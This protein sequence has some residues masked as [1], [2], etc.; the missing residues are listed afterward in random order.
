MKKIDERKIKRDRYLTKE[1]TVALMA[2][3]G[4]I[5]NSLTANATKITAGSTGGTTITNKDGVYDIETTNKKGNNA[6]NHFNQFELSPNNI[7]NMYFGTKQDNSA[8]NL[9]NFV[10]SRIEVN[11]TVNAIK[12]N[13]IGGDLYFLSS[14]GM[15]VGNTGTINTGS[16]HVITPSKTAYADA[17]QKAGAGVVAEGIVPDAKGQIKIP[18]NP[19]GT[20]VVRGQVNAVD[21]IG[22]YA[23]NIK[24]GNVKS[25]LVKDTDYTPKVNLKTGVTDFSNL[26]NIQGIDSGLKGEQLQA[27]KIGNG[28]IILMAKAEAE[29][30][31]DQAFNDMLGDIITL[32]RLDG[33]VPRNIKAS[34]EI[35]G[36]ITATGDI[37]AKAEAVNGTVSAIDEKT[38][39]VLYNSN[40]LV[41][42]TAK[43]DIKGGTLTAKNIDIDAVSTNKYIE[44]V[45][46]ATGNTTGAQGSAGILGQ[47]IK[48][49]GSIGA[50][51]GD[52]TVNIAKGSIID[53][54]ENLEINAKND[55]SLTLGSSVSARKSK[56]AKL[57]AMA[58]MEGKPGAF[59]YLPATG[60]AIGYAEG[61]ASVNVDGTLKSGG[62]M[63]IEASS[64]NEMDLNATAM[65]NKADNKLVVGLGLA[66]GNNSSSV[67]LNGATVNSSG[68]L[69][70]NSTTTNSLTSIV[71]VVAGNATPFATTVNLV[72]YD[73]SSNINIKDSS[74][75]SGENIDID[76][77]N[78]V[79]ENKIISDNTA[80]KKKTWLQ[81]FKTDKLTA[82]KNSEEA[83]KLVDNLKNLTGFGSGASPVANGE[84]G[85]QAEKKKGIGE[86]IALGAAMAF[87]GEEN[88]SSVNIQGSSINAK[89]DLNINSKTHIQDTLM[90]VAGDTVR[91][92]KTNVIIGAG[93]LYG[94]V[95]NTSSIVIDGEQVN[96]KDNKASVITTENGKI[97]IHSTT[98]MDYARVDKM[99]QELKNSIA[100]LK[101]ALN[102]LKNYSLSE[103]VKN[104]IAEL[105]NNLEGLGTE[106]NNFGSNMQGV[107]LDALFGED[108]VYQ[109][110][111]LIKQAQAV[112]DQL[113]ALSTALGENLTPDLASLM[114]S[115]T[116]SIMNATEFANVGN[117]GNFSVRATARNL[118][119][120]VGI[121]GAVSITNLQNDSK[122]VIGKGTTVNAKKD[123][124]IESTNKVDAVNVGG[125]IGQL[126]IKANGGGEKEDGVAIGGSFVMQ[127]FDSNNIIAVAEGAKLKG[128]NINITAD[129]DIFNVDAVLSAGKSAGSAIN[130]MVSYST[131]SIN[132]IVAIDDEVLLETTG[133]TTEET[134]DDNIT[135]KADSNAFVVNVAGGVAKGGNVGAGVGVA[136]NEFD[137]NNKIEIKD[138]DTNQELSNLVGHQHKNKV[139]DVIKNLSVGDL[140]FTDDKEDKQNQNPNMGVFKEDKLTI[141]KAD[142]GIKTSNFDASTLTKGE[143]NSVSVAGSVSSKSEGEEEKEGI[144][145]SLKNN[146]DS[147]VD[148]FNKKI[149]E[150]IGKFNNNGA[151][152]DLMNK[153]NSFNSSG[154]TV[155]AGGGSTESNNVV[156]NTGAAKPTINVAVA[157]SSS[158]NII[159][160]VTKT[161]VDG[162]DINLRGENSSVN[163]SAKDESFTGAWSGAAA[164]NWITK[165][166]A[167]TESGGSGNSQVSSGTSVGVHGAVGINIVDRETTAQ[168][169]NSTIKDADSIN[170][171]SVNDSVTVAAGLGLGLAKVSGAGNKNYQGGASVSLN[172]ITHNTNAFLENIDT[173]NENR[174]SNIKVNA[175]ESG[176]QVTG[177]EN[178]NAGQSSGAMGAAVTV[179]NIN[180]TINTGIKGGN[181]QD[182]ENVNVDGTLDMTQVTAAAA[183]GATSQEGSIGV[184]EGAVVYNGTNNIVNSSID[185][186]NIDASGD[187]N[188][189]AGDTKSSSDQNKYTETLKEFGIDSTGE[190]YYNGLE[191]G[192]SG[193]G[194][195]ATI[196]NNKSGS[197][198][199]TGALSVAGSN[200][201]ALGAGVVVNNVANKFTA[202]IKGTNINTISAD[203]VNVGAAAD[204]FIVG[205]AGGVGVG[206]DT[207]GGMGSVSWQELTN[208]VVSKISGVNITARE[209]NVTSKNN[210]FETNSAGQITYGGK[211]AA[212]AA[213]AYTNI[214]NL[215]SAT[216][217]NTT[218]NLKTDGDNPQE[219]NVNVVAESGVENYT[220]AAGVS[221]SA[222]NA[223]VAGS[224]AVAQGGNSTL[225]TIDKTTIKDVDNLNTI[226]T[227][228][229]KV[230]TIAGTVTGSKGAAIG[231]SG[232]YS[233]LAKNEVKAALNSVNITTG[234]NGNI[235]IGA[236]ETSKFYTIGAGVGGSGQVAVQ[237]A[238]SISQINKT[239]N[240][241]MENT[242]INSEEDLEE[243][244]TDLNIIAQSTGEVTSNASVIGGAGTAA[245]GAGTAV[246]NITQNTTATLDGGDQNL[247]NALIKAKSLANITT[248][249]IGGTGAG[250]VGITG[251]VAINQINNNTKTTVANNT[252]IANGSIG[253]IAQSDDVISN[254]AGTVAGGG[255][256]AIGAS[257]SVNQISGDTL[258]TLNNANITANGN[259][260]GIEVNSKIED[261][262][263]IDSIIDEETAQLGNNLDSKRKTEPIKGIVI[264]S[265]ATHTLKSLLANGGIAGT[266]AV[267]GTVNVNQIDGNTGANILGST[268][269]SAKNLSV[270][271]KDYTNS[272]GIV[273]TIAAGMNAGVGASSDTNIVDRDANVTIGNSHLTG[274]NLD[275]D[276]TSKQGISSFGMGFGAAV[277]GAG[278][279][280]TVTVVD[281]K[282]DTS[283]IIKDDSDITAIDGNIDINADHYGTI[284]TGTGAG[285]VAGIGAGVGAAVSVIK[286]ENHTIIDIAK[287]D[288]TANRDVNIE[289]NN[290]SKVTP[291]VTAV[292]VAGLG[293]GVAGTVAIN[294]IA[295]VVATNITDSTIK[296]N[297]GNIGISSKNR[298]ENNLVGVGVSGG[299]VGV[300][301]VVN[302]NTVDSAVATNISGTTITADNGDIKVNT[303]EER[304][305]QQV[306]TNVAGGAVAVGANVL[307]NNFGKAEN[308]GIDLDDYYV[309]ANSASGKDKYDSRVDSILK[310][311]GIQ[312]DSNIT[313]DQGGSNPD[314]NYKTGIKV[315][316]DNGSKLVGNN[317]NVKAKE[318][319]NI[320][321]TSVGVSAGVAGAS[322][323]VAITNINRNV[324]INITNSNIEAKNKVNIEANTTGNVNLDVWQG[325]AGVASI[326]AAYGA[327]NS[328]GKSLVN[329]SG[330]NLTSGSIDVA[331]KDNLAISSKASGLTGGVI[332]AG[333][334]VSQAEN[335]GNVEINLE[336]STLTS[337]DDKNGKIN[338]EA[339][340]A[341]DVKAEAIG[342]SVGITTGAGVTAIAKD[343]GNSNIA[344]NKGN[345][346]KGNNF[347][348]KALNMPSVIAKSGSASVGLLE[349]VGVSVTNAIVDA[350][351]GIKIADGNN[352][353]VNNANIIGEIGIQSGKKTVI[354][355]TDSISGGYVTSDFNIAFAKTNSDVTVDIGKL[356]YKENNGTNLFVHGKNNTETSIDIA[357]IGIGGLIAMGTNVGTIE[358]TNNT[359]V[360]GAGGNLKNATFEATSS[361][362]NS[363][364]ADGSGGGRIDATGIAALAENTMIGNTKVELSG[365]WNVAEELKANAFETSKANLVA[366][367]LRAAGIGVSGTKVDNIIKGAGAQVIFKDNINIVG[368]GSVLAQAKNVIDVTEIGKGS[369]YGGLTVQG[370]Y[371]NNTVN[372]DAKVIIGTGVNIKTDGK[373]SYDATTDTD[374]DITAH[375]KAAGAGVVPHAHLI[376]NVTINN[377]VQFGENSTLKTNKEKQDITLASSNNLTGDIKAT[378][379]IPGGALG[380]ATASVNNNIG[381]KDTVEVNGTIYSTDNVNLYTGMNRD[382]NKEKLDVK[383][384]AE[385]F[386]RTAIPLATAPSISNKISQNNKTSVTA[387]GNIQS[388]RDINVVATGGDDLIRKNTA[389]YT[390]V[391]GNGKDY[392]TVSN[393]S[394][395][396][397]SDV[398]TDNVAELNGK[399]T[400]GVQNKQN[401][402]IDGIVDILG[403]PEGIKYEDLTDK[404]KESFREL[405]EK[406]LK[407]SEKTEEKIESLA[408]EIFNERAIVKGAT[409]KPEISGEYAGEIKYGIMKYGSSLFNRYQELQELVNSYNSGENSD[410]KAYLGY[411]TEQARILDEL[412]KLNLVSRDSK[413]N[414]VPIA[415]MEVQFIELPD[416]I[417]SG[418]NI[419]INADNLTGK[420]ELVAKGAPEI[421]ITNNSNL[422][423]KVNDLKIGEPGGNIKFNDIGIDNGDNNAITRLNKDKKYTANFAK[424]ETSDSKDAKIIIENTWEGNL[425]VEYKDNDKIK[426]Q[427]LK[428]LVNIEINGNIENMY[429][430]VNISNKE[431]DIIIQGKDVQSG[432]SID[433]KEV[434]LS[435]VK[436]S[437]SQ[438]YT[439]GIVNIGSNPQS[440]WQGTHNSTIDGIKKDDPKL[441]KPADN[442][443][444]VESTEK[445][446]GNG[447]RIA[448]GSIYIN[449]A[450]INLNGYVQSGYEDYELNLGSD[451]NNKI[452]NYKK[453]YKG[454]E[455]T[456]DQLKNYKLNDGG[457]YEKQADGT[458]K[459]IV[460]AYYNP[461]TDEIV[462]ED[463]NPT[464]GKVYLTGRVTSTGGG[465]I[466]A[467]D[468][469]TDIDITNNTGINLSVGNINNNNINGLISITDTREVNGKQ[470]SYT[471]EYTRNGV[472]TKEVGT[473]NIVNLD[474]V[475]ANKYTPD[476]G[477]RYNWTEG[478]ETSTKDKY[479][480][481][482]YFKW[483]GAY[484]SKRDELNKYEKEENKVPVPGGNNETAK[485]DGIYIGKVTEIDNNKEYVFI[486][487]NDVSMNKTTIKEWTEYANWLHFKGWQHYEWTH[488]TGSTQTYMSSVKADHAI[489][490]GFIGQANGTIDINSN[491]NI[492]LNGSLKNNNSLGTTTI[493]TTT[494]SIMQNGGT[495]HSD[496][497]N[498]NAVTGI[499]NINISSIGDNI[500]LNAVTTNGDIIIGTTSGLK[501]GK[502]TQGNLVLNKV[503]TGSGVVDLSAQG[504]IVQKGSGVSVQGNRINL[505]STLGGIDLIVQ[506]GTEVLSTG[507]SLSN[508]IN[509]KAKNNISLT[510]ANGDFRIGTVESE[511]GDVTIK[512]NNGSL[513]DAL[514]TGEMQTD[515]STED[516][517]ERWKELGLITGSEEYLAAKKQEAEEYKNSIENEYNSYLSLKTR[518]ENSEISPEEIQKDSTYK[519]Y[520]ELSVKYQ[521]YSSVE[522]YL[523]KDLKY[524]ELNKTPEYQWTE[525]DLL[526][527]IQE[528]IVNQT[529]GSTQ[530]EIKTP[531]IIGKNITIDASNGV[532]IDAGS[533]TVDLSTLTAND[534]AG[535]KKLAAAE[536]ADVVWD[537]ANNR[538]TIIKK[539]PIGIQMKG[540]EGKL[541]VNAKDNIYIAART[542]VAGGNT[543]TNTIYVDNI[544]TDGNIRV[545]G[546]G[547]VF[548][549]SQSGPN[550]T[551]NN[552]IVEGGTGDLG[553]VNKALTMNLK[554][555][556][557]ARSDG[558]IYLNQTAGDMNVAA[559]YAGKNVN[560]I[561][562][563]NIFSTN[564]NVGE[565]A[566]STSGTDEEGDENL[567][568][569]YINAGEGITLSATEDIGKE[570]QGLNILNGKTHAVNATGNNIYLQGKKDGTLLLGN[571]NAT[572][573]IIVKSEDSIKTSENINGND[574]TFTAENSI[575]LGNDEKTTTITSENLILTA[576][577]GNINQLENNNIVSNIVKAN[578][579]TG[580]NLGSETN[581]FN[582][583][584]LGNNRGD[585]LVNNSGANG[586]GV[587]FDRT[588]NAGNIT[589]NNSTGNLVINNSATTTGENDIVLNN[590]TGDI[591]VAKDA[592]LTAGKDI[593]MTTTG[594]IATNNSTLVATNK[595]GLSATGNIE[596][597]GNISGNDVEMTSTTGSINTNSSEI[598]AINNVTL[599]AA[600]DITNKNIIT[601]GKD[602]LVSNVNGDLLLNKLEG[603]NIALNTTNGNITLTGNSTANAGNIKVTLGTATK[604]G[605]T[606]NGNLVAS[607]NVDISSTTGN[608]AIT[609][610]ITAKNDVLAK[611]E[612]GDI[613]IT[614][615]T[616]GAN[617]VAINTTDGDITVKGDT[618]ATTGNVTM[619]ATTGDVT[620]SGNTTAKAGDIKVTLG[621]ATKG[622][623]TVNG[624]LVANQDINISTNKGNVGITGSLTSG[625]DTTVTTTEGIITLDKGENKYL[626]QSGKDVS[627]STGTGAITAT[628]NIT[629][630]NNVAL[631]TT[632]GD[633]TIK[634]DTEATEG[635]VT[636]GTS[637]TGDIV[638]TGNLV[639]KK[640]I[641]VSTSKGNIGVTGSLTSGSDTTVSTT[642]GNIGVTGNLTSGI[643]TTIATNKVGNITL[644]G[645][646]TSSEDTL[647]STKEGN[648]TL[649]AGTD[650]NATKDITL[651][652]ETGSI[653][654]SKSNLIS[655][656]N[657]IAKAINGVIK[658]AGLMKADKDIS[659]NTTTGSIDLAGE[660][661]ANNVTIGA[662]TGD[663][664]LTGNT[665]AKAGDVKVTLGTAKDKGITVNGNLVA[666]NNVDISSTTGNVTIT[667]DITAEN[668]VLAKAETG[669]ITITGNTI[670]TN[671]VAL[672]TTDGN[673][674]VKGDTETTTGNA[675]IV[676]AEKGNINV[677]GNLTS[678]KD[679]IIAT[680]KIG[681]ITL[682]GDIT[683]SE[684][685]VVSTKDGDITLVAGTDI[686]AT[687]DITL[688]TEKGDITGVESQLISGNNLI[689]KAINGVIKLAGLMRA[690]KDLSVNTT[691]GSIDLTGERTANNVIIG[692]TTGDIALNG[693]TTARDG[694]IQ[695]ALGT[696]TKDGITVSGNLVANNDVN[697]SSTKGNISITGDITAENDILAKVETGN[698][699]ITGNTIGTNNVAL[700]TTD[701]NITVKGDTE[702]TTGN[703]TIV[704]A[705]KG[706]I[707]VVGNLTSGKDTI[708]ATNKIG[709]ITLNGDITSS[710]DTVVSTK[711]GDITLVA[712]TDINATNDITLST[713]K[714]DIT[715]VESQLISGD[716]LTVK[717]ETGDVT[718][719]GG[720]RVENN[721]SVNTIT[722]SIDLTGNINTKGDTLFLTNSGNIVVNKDR[723]DL[724]VTSGNNF[725]AKTTDGDIILD[726]NVVSNGEGKVETSTTGNININNLV[727]QDNLYVTTATGDIVGNHLES[728][729]GKVYI[730]SA[731]KGKVTINN[732]KAETTADITTKDGDIDITNLLAN[733]K[734]N[735]STENGSITS[736]GSL[737]S[738]NES[739]KVY[740]AKGDIQIND[741]Y[742]KGENRV[743]AK[744]GNIYIKKIN[745]DYVI[746]TLGNK[747]KV[748]KVDETIVGKGAILSSNDITIDDFGQREGETNPVEITFNNSKDNKN[749]PINNI[750]LHTKGIENGIKVNQLWVHDAN[751]TTDSSILQ[752]PELVVT[753]K[754]VFANN[755]TTATVYGENSIFDNSNIH[756]W[757][758]AD[759]KE[760]IT[761]NFLPQ[762]NTVF[763]DG[764]LL[765]LQDGYNVYYQR[766]TA[767]DYMINHLKDYLSLEHKLD[768]IRDPFNY[769][770]NPYLQ[771]NLIDNNIKF[772]SSLEIVATEDDKII[773]KEDGEIAEITID[774]SMKV[775]EKNKDL[776]EMIISVK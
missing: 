165:K 767:K 732:I 126:V 355:E 676:T 224:V 471:T 504:N 622:G 658:L 469:S 415:D 377:S 271:A 517:I 624:N 274:S 418:G 286:D 334:I 166:G 657:L 210:A 121:A 42:T 281:L 386:N 635:T 81:K 731:N 715:G 353:L 269:N 556:L 649:V 463:I 631:N 454:G 146:I 44:L 759:K 335:N 217:E 666:S 194:D 15:V 640:D 149:N 430:Q 595:V 464:G 82:I 472:V 63:K 677:V 337:T 511:A 346:F 528:D 143:I 225:A 411:K 209:V 594:N 248:I 432:A 744:D 648:I 85:G 434:I 259:G 470:V 477:L 557:T 20:I 512:V 23:A 203:T 421:S 525:N 465:K 401:I 510:Q 366:D 582:S 763:T 772:N 673:I 189:T 441:E 579:N 475:T 758:D 89:E 291:T 277:Q 455:L 552:L 55:V 287:T 31:D 581:K 693:T 358:S 170:V 153:G 333:A 541:N 574:V 452:A 636:I 457:K 526:Y 491:S 460:Q 216:I 295:S 95:G 191:T 251:S 245:I 139:L 503:N 388:V 360:K 33:V 551:G 686:N 629:G 219:K 9:F 518:Y 150:T 160:N 606:V 619:G 590:G 642:E 699:N 589:I 761:L 173:K 398:T 534:Y 685:T 707:N 135:I 115:V 260:N 468:G 481:H 105:E 64:S 372:K 752:F 177:G 585:I 208:D 480:M 502:L 283:V 104:T 370:S 221:A 645:D 289:A 190:G 308:L 588:E 435:A 757:N 74:I 709:D 774:P 114:S 560:L 406:L 764:R 689:A 615:D 414:L 516:K 199:V 292:G 250:T 550:F 561:S 299:F 741:S 43:V 704:T 167:S 331:N 604:D 735:I 214:E 571:I 70:I 687:N 641:N 315:N 613:N 536:A 246:N 479:E 683:S 144:L 598:K 30:S 697:I 696:A 130:G 368:T 563:G 562:A 241:S 309:Q 419:T 623:I 300:G 357:G 288:I 347:T 544:T 52:A 450:D 276:A 298:F 228:E 742:V 638:L 397:S 120:D 721:L 207:F 413:G 630:T 509:A 80:G 663:V 751:I 318:I 310:E 181:L 163:I 86:K 65:L 148:N 508:S 669:N 499:K 737:S 384:A 123:L 325:S 68:N 157:G 350:K 176:I 705:E 375:V 532:G 336:G 4:F 549:V 483:W 688:S 51:K 66:V 73:S 29:S 498:L 92:K 154:T 466:V 61:N 204:T 103:A 647:V 168:I 140:I 446:S 36:D 771:Y 545:L 101:T 533:E 713:E 349:D 429:G 106:V 385:A 53:A 305:I 266:A 313:A 37:V 147:T 255:T 152:N 151:V 625:L 48:I 102:D 760:W 316:I 88:T 485:K 539:N 529:S 489:D 343:S 679:T 365:D 542:D 188:V 72:A 364:N 307:V 16:L 592:N 718:L 41:S 131:G 393:S 32:D 21:E 223:A 605:I 668:D 133:N 247:E 378:A 662:A 740:S 467:L 5:V 1:K 339:E 280:G 50:L 172:D 317:V 576:N 268:L 174:K 35:N 7:A 462:V 8:E 303:E 252:L 628:G 278:V 765:K 389:E 726:G 723:K 373:Q 717:A 338:I 690:D 236:K 578:A 69:D 425:T 122:I 519:T 387:T 79:T 593:T 587:T 665:T 392:T 694:D 769:L 46:G 486:Y 38:G 395:K 710:E 330:T 396:G 232:A 182:I 361:T 76:S 439:D 14:D 678:G 575:I 128:S 725:T 273:G 230:Y 267:N 660:R 94:Q 142:T 54:K 540:S 701:G 60:A 256:A 270:S 180:N 748:M 407:N 11:G 383:L 722:G 354:A 282:G 584:N 488:E 514:P 664:T 201:N 129:N 374:L 564:V 431:G 448:G 523:A 682:N 730:S 447:I 531:N 596:T 352:I 586:L 2:T 200:S 703:A 700:N 608:V 193:D 212:G 342:G 227:D 459:Y 195:R 184:F 332:A 602:I 674:T 348:V 572:G 727:T 440:Q 714:G 302:V 554:G 124:N 158:T 600:K 416:I 675:T 495:I 632:D 505:D 226:A 235:N 242:N 627:I 118:K 39:D 618:E 381:R 428:P 71:D 537:E 524:A 626:V 359:L 437:V 656:N 555:T 473:G 17:I 297:S 417:A 253:A 494:G 296:S 183:I 695:I 591:T 326:G 506:G 258:V 670:G 78:I 728:I 112:S 426:T 659:V 109:S 322:G 420:G 345:T 612:T 376:N 762:E 496:N 98:Q 28:N 75:T 84:T 382:G 93:V 249:G 304:D 284:N 577:Q 206:K 99:V 747:D 501:D 724:N 162:I 231:G 263:I 243:R 108:G 87:V 706:N 77:Q 340:K 530:K 19:E 6:F 433:G 238:A 739:M 601:A 497:I 362:N 500:N 113:T 655:G 633:I 599:E 145:D 58:G 569:G 716:N 404:Q 62:D 155:A 617:D 320:E 186:A 719:A 127:D 753:G 720:M 445:K 116:D 547:G 97:N 22:L 215:T 620:L 754:G 137:V 119:G 583:I 240:A 513:V 566:G 538:A 132:N 293:A 443:L 91:D 301:A 493:N 197:T 403:I 47:K 755:S 327:I 161:E 438:G 559:I 611:V 67:N 422:Y 261:N 565:N 484:T 770:Y 738:V 229:N 369:G 328:F 746:I 580:I 671:N 329:L 427:E 125:N 294:N 654:G 637:E 444:K 371:V 100:N 367:A 476:S 449:A 667:G 436:G 363:I 196:E 650:I 768:E 314:S 644:D 279:A 156:D 607:N 442:Q 356:N 311:N 202:E 306:V 254:Y 610:D 290:I 171:E 244:Q 698:I 412:E 652:T 681:D 262:S 379:D 522:D 178:I 634:G 24:I 603:G 380:V 766:I 733:K 26:V 691:T 776:N 341:N 451:L 478:Y 13:K 609:G 321:S 597:A 185:G 211:A 567:V 110:F 456:N 96:G 558:S 570:N 661:V 492:A 453:N 49:D 521:D 775:L 218:I 548:N 264:D 400:A 646:I 275:I 711:D 773:I 680:N 684:D 527:A 621:T 179:A 736:K 743:I 136:I 323:T 164:I 614:G 515:Y 83:Q 507:D 573:N 272:S 729:D 159:D 756:I 749:A 708:I 487:D 27:T 175:L 56:W 3:L 324:G 117:Y 490:I 34:I 408:K 394:N 344:V 213:L 57:K 351:A 543:T 90:S 187:I 520:E 734:V 257:V 410:N 639:A 391:T 423:L 59:S 750:E 107:E 745:G 45:G 25:E 702:T 405:A 192:V 134:T 402:V 138:N 482:E 461:Y 312:T 222:G 18:L 111:A 12:N 265:S 568:L 409:N 285:A 424:I 553:A 643:D 546:T 535:M 234:A 616:T 239:V 220:V 390:W 169:K 458:Y 672:N 712:G 10:N 653:T 40:P 237:G 399:L 205:A 474:G 692:A 198:I 233:E 651:S 319:N 141:A